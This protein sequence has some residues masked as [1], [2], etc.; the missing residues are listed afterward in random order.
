MI[1]N[2]ADTHTSKSEIPNVKSLTSSLMYIEKYE[3][4]KEGFLYPSE[5][6]GIVVHVE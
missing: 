3:V 6:T 2:S 4:K 5:E 1:D